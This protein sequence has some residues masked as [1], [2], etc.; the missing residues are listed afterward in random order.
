MIFVN[1]LHASPPA[2]TVMPGP[3]MVA[4]ERYCADTVYDPPMYS[5]A[6]LQ[7]TPEEGRKLGAAIF[8]PSLETK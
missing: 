4:I 1:V 3:T 8:E 7:L 5:Q 2:A 6:V